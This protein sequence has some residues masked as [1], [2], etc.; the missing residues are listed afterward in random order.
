MELFK[1]LVG[2][3]LF[4]RMWSCAAPAPLPTPNVATVQVTVTTL[5]QPSSD[6]VMQFNVYQDGVKMNTT[7]V[8]SS[9]FVYKTKLRRGTTHTNYVKAV[10]NGL[11]SPPSN[12]ALWT[13]P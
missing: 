7:V 8:T 9:S 13:V 2:L 4:Y 6:G 10:I 1:F 11:E 12:S 3:M 5:W